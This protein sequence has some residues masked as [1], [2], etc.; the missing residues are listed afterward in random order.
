MRKQRNMPQM[1]Q[2]EKT[3]ENKLNEIEASNLPE[4]EFKV[5]IIKML[6]EHMGRMDEHNENLNREIVSIKKDI[7]TIK[8]NQT[9]IRNTITEMKNTLEGFNN[10]LDKAED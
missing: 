4:T 10:R 1:K 5:M 3:T 7:E 6:N 2:Q 9:E 8:K